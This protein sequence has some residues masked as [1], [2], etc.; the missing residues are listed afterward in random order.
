MTPGAAG[1]RASLDDL[2]DFDDLPGSG[3]RFRVALEHA[4][5]GGAGGSTAE[6]LTQIARVE[7]LQQRFADAIATLAAA[8]AAL[9]PAD[10]RGRCRLCLERG[11]VANSSGA[12]GRGRADFMA[13]W[14]LASTAGEEALAVDAA[15]MLGIVEPAADA[16]EWNRRATALALSSSDPRA[17]RWVASL[18]NNMGWAAHDAGRLDEALELFRLALDERLPQGNVPTIRIAR[19]SVAR[20]LRSLGRAEDALDDQRALLAEHE[21]EGTT[22]GY[23]CEEIAECLLA[24]GREDEAW[25]FFARAHAELAVDI[26]L[27][28]AQPERLERLRLLG[29][30]GAAPQSRR[31]AWSW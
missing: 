23:V 1:P 26:D 13:A 7:G 16:A 21:A 9:V 11:R 24:L 14:E 10:E 17:R 18:A 20:C 5:A 2:W 25:S 27:A 4:R 31:A 29:A 22:D 3:E 15:H 6:V 12:E 30:E 28:G 8:E 19:W